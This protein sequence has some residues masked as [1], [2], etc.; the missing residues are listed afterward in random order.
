MIE[1]QLNFLVKWK[2]HETHTFVPAPILNKWVP[3]SVST[4]HPNYLA[5]LHQWPS[6]SFM[7][8]ESVLTSQNRGKR[9]TVRAK[10]KTEIRRKWNEMRSQRIWRSS[11]Y[12]NRNYSNKSYCSCSKADHRWKTP[13]TRTNKRRRQQKSCRVLAAMFSFNTT[14]TRDK[15]NARGVKQQCSWKN[16]R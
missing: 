12:S 5:E 14:L 3:Q 13:K 9:A 11:W 15:F 1:G 2:G 4:L 8:V 7:K 6:F 10:K 16:R